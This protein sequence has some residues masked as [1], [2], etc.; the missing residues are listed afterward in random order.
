MTVLCNISIW[1]FR[2][3]IPFRFHSSVSMKLNGISMNLALLFIKTQ[4][5]LAWRCYCSVRIIYRLSSH[6]YMIPLTTLIAFSTVTWCEMASQT[7]TQLQII[8]TCDFQQAYTQ[9]RLLPFHS[10]GIFYL[11]CIFS[12]SLYV[13]FRFL[14]AVY[15]LLCFLCSHIMYFVRKLI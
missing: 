8:S 2:F 3:S 9:Y 5:Q 12:S 4:Q 13:R 1:E 11:M 7:T 10:D 6:L 15:I 14:Y